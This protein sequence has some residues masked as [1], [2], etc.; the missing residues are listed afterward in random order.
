MAVS[1]VR[2]RRDRLRA[3]GGLV[4]LAVLGIVL[5]VHWSVWR[6]PFEDAAGLR[7]LLLLGLGLGALGWLV[8]PGPPLRLLG[9]AGL[10]GAGLLL[11]LA[12]LPALAR[13]HPSMQLTLQPD[14]RLL[15]RY[16][17]AARGDSTWDA[18]HLLMADFLRGKPVYYAPGSSLTPWKLLA[19]S[20]PS[21]IVELALPA[22]PLPDGRELMRGL[23][24]RVMTG[25]WEGHVYRLLA[26]TE[27][28]GRAEYFVVAKLGETDLIC[29]DS[30]WEKRVLHRVQPGD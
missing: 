8:R 16:G 2:V 6:P 20:R 24:K 14:A 28:A 25:E 12:W 9:A 23:R 18:A 5:A 10:A 26:I 13:E 22:G 3:V 19:L 29:P 11:G 1:N 7:W 27:G 17:Q 21:E 15:T 4:C 30:I